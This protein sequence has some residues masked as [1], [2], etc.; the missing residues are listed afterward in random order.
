MF[1]GPD[2]TYITAGMC[3]SVRLDN[4]PSEVTIGVNAHCLKL[5]ARAGRC[6]TSRRSR[7][8]FTGTGR[9]ARWRLHVNE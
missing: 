6:V 9:G 8:Q 4:G 7:G 3:A 1:I 2:F 5:S